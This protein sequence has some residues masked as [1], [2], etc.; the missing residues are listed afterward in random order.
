MVQ[1]AVAHG[2]EL[3]DEL[4]ILMDQWAEFLGTHNF[5]LYDR[6]GVAILADAP[7]QALG[8]KYRTPLVLHGEVFATL[9][10]AYDVTPLRESRLFQ[11][12]L[13]ATAL[14]ITE[15]T[16]WAE[17]EAERRGEKVR[18][19]MEYGLTPE[20]RQLLSLCGLDDS[21]GK[22]FIAF[23][24]AMPLPFQGME[25]LR[26][27]LI[28]Q[29]WRYSRNFP[30][31]AYLPDGLLILN[32]WSW[33]KSQRHV[34]H[35]MDRW[36]QEATFPVRAYLQML[37][38]LRALPEILKETRSVMQFADQF[39]LDGLINEVVDRHMIRFV[40]QMTPESLEDFINTVLGPLLSDEHQ[41]TLV[42][43]K[44]YLACGQSLSKTA[45]NLYVHPNTVLYR[46]RRAEKLLGITLKDTEQLTNLWI[47][48][49]GHTLLNNVHKF[50]G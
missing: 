7:E 24:T 21:E 33:E 20:V 17:T 22:T 28:A 19:V 34:A 14:M 4:Q 16:E 46:V 29:A 49:E 12:L 18:L 1:I 26:R 35:W 48:L 47:A 11:T 10:S 42:T 40:L 44:Q 25:V 3:L 27:Y 31:L 2:N 23:E 39:G 38:N 50:H 37:P 45:H 41:A 13:L 8:L 6:Y 30:W 15:L 5:V 43:L 9:V 36:K 32:S